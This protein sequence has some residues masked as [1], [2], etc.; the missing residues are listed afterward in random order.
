[1][2]YLRLS[3]LAILLLAVAGT[4]ADDKQDKTPPGAAILKMTPEQLLK[5]WD[6]NKDGFVDKE[7][8]PAQ[9]QQFFEQFDRNGDGKLDVKEIGPA[10]RD[11]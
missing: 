4:Y 2:H 5:L 1:M 9:V 10:P 7:E 3:T 11:T 8:L 6:K